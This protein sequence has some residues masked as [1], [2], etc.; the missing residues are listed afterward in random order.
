V[1]QVHA[2]QTNGGQF[3]VGIGKI[4][5]FHKKYFFS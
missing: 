1:A 3:L 2:T 4:S 5:V